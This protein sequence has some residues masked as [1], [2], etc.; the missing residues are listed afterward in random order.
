M[1][2]AAFPMARVEDAGMDRLVGAP[3]ALEFVR[4]LAFD[5]PSSS[6]DAAFSSQE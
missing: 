3:E 4:R 2:K 5:A 6:F 1:T